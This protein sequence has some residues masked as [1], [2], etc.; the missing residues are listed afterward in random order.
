MKRVFQ[1]LAITVLAGMLV[2]GGGIVL[3]GCSSATSGTNNNTVPSNKSL[4][5]Y[6]FP[7][8]AATGVISGNA[9]SVDVPY[10]T[11]VTALVAAFATNGASVKVGSTAQV[12]GT[13]AN[14]FTS[15]VTYTV[16]AADQSHQD[17]TVRVPV[18][19]AAP[20]ISTASE[21]EQ[22]A[23][24][25]ATGV[26]DSSDFTGYV[27]VAADAAQNDSTITGI[28]YT[29]TGTVAA[30]NYTWTISLSNYHAAPV[31]GNGDPIANYDNHVTGT[32]LIKQTPDPVNS[33]L[34]TQFQAG[35]FTVTGTQTGT[36]S[37]VLSKDTSGAV[38]STF[39]IN[40]TRY[41]WGGN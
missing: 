38:S 29:K 39:T 37:F 25:A 23:Y 20:D 11:D 2:L 3:A 34:Y 5:A 19:A 24:S 16:T 7:L 41:G 32:L 22:E 26:T 27:S 9:I 4:T 35:S 1:T 13:T 21:A 31:D 36:L 15:P 12:S 17:Y 8:L 14:D 33:N 18:A 30:H 40:G 28:T 6:S 10:G